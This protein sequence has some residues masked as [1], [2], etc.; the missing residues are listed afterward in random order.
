MLRSSQSRSIGERGDL[1]HVDA[2]ADDGPALGNRSERGRNKLSCR[3]EDDRGVDWFRRSLQR[4]ARPF[5][6]QGACEVLALHVPWAGEDEDTSALPAG[7]L[8]D[9]VRRGPKPEQAEQWWVPGESQRAVPNQAGTQQRSGLQVRVPLRHQKAVPRIGQR[10]LGEA[11]IDR[12][13]RE[14][15]AVAEVL[16]AA[17]AE[18]AAAAGPAEPG[19]AHTLPQAEA[20]DAAAKLQH[21][22]DDL[23]AE[24]Q[25][26]FRLGELAVDDVQVGAADPTDVNLQRQLALTGLT[27][28]KI[29]FLQ[30]SPDAV[31]HHRTH[32]DPRPSSPGSSVL[33]EEAYLVHLVHVGADQRHGWRRLFVIWAC[34]SR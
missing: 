4:R 14:A 27:V 22:T 13:A 33:E 19:N 9:D 12:V 31:E 3:R 20:C 1:A 16:A 2:C 23:M 30:G 28:R 29:G 6:A 26:E 8:A 7:D 5:C 17:A 10:L 32:R 25:W 34:P 21:R 11:A 18:A 24:H 15:R